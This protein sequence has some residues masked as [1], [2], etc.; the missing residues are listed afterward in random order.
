MDWKNKFE[1]TQ[2]QQKK[3]WQKTEY[4]SAKLAKITGRR[5]KLVDPQLHNCVPADCKIVKV[6]IY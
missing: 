1:F 2:K 6:I 4:K 5:K 3:E